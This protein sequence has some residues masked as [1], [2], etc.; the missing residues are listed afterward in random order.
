MD[1][2]LA[3]ERPDVMLLASITNP[4][5]PQ[6]DH[7]RSAHALGIPTGICV[8]SWDHL[9]SKALIRLQPDRVLVWNDTQKR[10]A[11]DLHGIPADRV[12][13]TGAQCYDQLFE[14][15]PERSRDD[16]CRA[17]GL[18]SDRPYLLYLCS[19]M[20][21]DPGEATFVVEW[22]RA[23]RQ[24]ADARLRTAGVLIR[25]H[26]ERRSE[27]DD[28]DLTGLD[29]VV[30]HGNT[31]FT[32]DAKSDYYTG[33]AHSG[34]VVGLVTSAF[35]EA[36]IVGRPVLTLLRPE[37]AKHQEG[38]LHFRYLLDVEGGLLQ[39]ARNLEEH[40]A[41]LSPVLKGTGEWVAQ[42]QR[43]LRAFVRPRGLDVSATD[44][45]VEAVEG[46]GRVESETHARPRARAV[47]RLEPFVR[48]IIARSQRG[49]LMRPLL[50]DRREAEEERARSARIAQH[51]RAK[52]LRKQERR[53]ENAERLRV[54]LRDQAGAQQEGRA[55]KA[56]TKR[57][58]RRQKRSRVWT[59]RV[60]R[61]SFLGSLIRKRI[62]I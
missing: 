19:A 28:V 61:M 48:S 18:P 59:K 10:E 33:L 38:M 55:R 9:S 60:E 44:A 29:P 7:Q 2:F 35:L 20:T 25:P 47:S 58:K 22:L 46:I 56:E 1:A 42:Q 24:S 41:Q 45:F 21:P 23:I 6:L 13:V 17:V 11:V 15:R 5:A 39:V 37:L 14:W 40:L 57:T 52:R 49:Q 3:A 36:A 34:A 51:E 50:L 12:T 43:F 32:P 30:I 27:W 31:P 54:K 4:R 26:P 16:F 53:K 62:G 8:Y